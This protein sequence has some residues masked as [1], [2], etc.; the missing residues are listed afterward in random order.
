ME[1][2][3]KES[4]EDLAKATTHGNKSLVTCGRHY[5]QD[6]A[7]KSAEIE[8]KNRD[9]KMNKE[10]K[11]K[12]LGKENTEQEALAIIELE[13]PID[14]MTNTH[15]TKLLLWYGVKNPRWV[16]NLK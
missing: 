16:P 8:A 10:D 2:H 9:V 15:F 14:A 4:V 3:T 7:L 13:I 12:R 1:T 5:T 6:N 11:T